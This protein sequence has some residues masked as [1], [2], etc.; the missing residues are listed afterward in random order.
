MKSNTLSFFAIGVAVFLIVL[1]LTRPYWYLLR[2]RVLKTET[3]VAIHKGDCTY[4]GPGVAM[5][6]HFQLMGIDVSHHQGL[7]DWKKVKSS[8]IKARPLSF[9]FV[10][11]TYGRWKNDKYFT[12]NWKATRQVGILRGAYHYYLPNQSAKAQ[13]D[14]FIGRV[15]GPDGKYQGDL[16]PVLDIEESPP[17]TNISDFHQGIQIWLDEVENKTGLRPI[18]YSGAKFYKVRLYPAFKKYPLWVAH[19]KAASPSI[20]S[21]QTW[22]LWQ[23]TDKARINGICG[24][25][26]LN[27]SA[28]VPAFF[29]QSLLSQ[30]L[31]LN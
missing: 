6:A 28:D 31:V 8:Y 29:P 14:K 25:V 19:Y 7:I 24:P 21:T 30:P 23:F 26:D 4:S 1:S 2:K 13:A 3:D 18:I 11:A 10:R 16:P 15:C 12:Y 5:P 22:D 20:P 27:V 17:G 9:V